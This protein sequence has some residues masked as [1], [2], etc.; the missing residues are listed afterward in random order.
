MLN[1]IDGCCDIPLA[2]WSVATLGFLV[3]KSQPDAESVVC[4][5][6]QASLT[7]GWTATLTMLIPNNIDFELL[8][9]I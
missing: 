2:I 7:P 6:V 4:L 5:L 8:R 1:L 9:A 3:G